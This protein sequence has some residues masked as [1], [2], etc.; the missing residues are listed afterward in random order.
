MFEA[1][2]RN[3][4][5]N[6]WV[7]IG[8]VF[9]F[10]LLALIK[11]KYKSR[12]FYTSSYFLLKKHLQINYSAEK[13]IILNTYQ[14]LFF[15]VQAMLLALFAFALTTNYNIVISNTTVKS[16][17]IL[18]LG[19]LCYIIGYYTITYFIAQLFGI[20]KLL[21]RVVFNRTG[22]FNNLIIW[23]LPFVL[24]SYYSPI[25][26]QFW[27]KSSIIVFLILLIFRYF[28][29]IS[30]NK[31]LII[32]HFFYFILYICTLEIAPLILI[33]KLTI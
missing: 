31:R 17:L 12:L 11:V 14:G 19:I 25:L 16:L 5:N 9:I 7:T 23:F 29:I 2:L 21:Q 3:T 13:R 26:Q 32:A 33:Y 10:I 1:S 22:Y 30:S 20:K 6:D 15:L 18:F 8:F 24:L 27:F 28:L 4:F